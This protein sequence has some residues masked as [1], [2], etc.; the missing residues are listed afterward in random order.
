MSTKCTQNALQLTVV[1]T[2]STT[3]H[4]VH[5]AFQRLDGRSTERVKVFAATGFAVDVN[6]NPVRSF[7][8]ARIQVAH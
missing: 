8:M 6:T 7:A 5:V 2:P 1:I 3:T 4:S